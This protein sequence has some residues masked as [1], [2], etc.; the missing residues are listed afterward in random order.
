MNLS[1]SR[2]LKISRTDGG[3]TLIE[4][5]VVITI[6]IILSGI[7]LVSLN[8][9]RSKARDVKRISDLSQIQLALEQYFDRCH[10]YP[11]SLSSIAP[12]DCVSNPGLIYMSNFIS[13]IPRPPSGATPNQTNYDYCIALS[14]K[15]DYYLHAR[16]EKTVD[17]V[18]D[19]LSARPFACNPSDS[20][21]CSNAAG[22]LDY[23]IGPK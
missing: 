22:S 16:L 4:L 10:S 12:N 14:N 1:V 17:A 3:F 2:P 15:T 21:P 20:V 11:S 23:C 7:L 6:I 13:T 19:A 5:L 9:S 8:S 18:K